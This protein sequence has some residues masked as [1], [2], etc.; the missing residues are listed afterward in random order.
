VSNVTL[1]GI[2][3]LREL[4]LLDANGTRGAFT[5]ENSVSLGGYGRGGGGGGARRGGDDAPPLALD[6][7][8]RVDFVGAAQNA[9]VEIHDDLLLRVALS[10]A[11][12]RAPLVAELDG[13]L[14]LDLNAS[15]LFLSELADGG[16]TCLLSA[17][18]ALQ[19]SV[20]LCTVTFYANLAHS[21]TR[22]P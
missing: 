13:T 1:S 5:L 16:A 21:L 8:L 20:L 17:F 2:D 6:V 19:V 4:T 18:D 14:A 9:A 12:L 11:Q 10:N 3:S 22:S 7:A 15:A